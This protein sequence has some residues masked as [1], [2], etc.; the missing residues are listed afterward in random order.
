MAQR[1][2]SQ[3]WFY[4]M[5]GRHYGIYGLKTWDTGYSVH[6]T[7]RRCEVYDT[8]V[9]PSVAMNATLRLPDSSVIRDTEEE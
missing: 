4:H 1:R 2:V 9:T 8:C 6:Y 5:A 7:S 3:S